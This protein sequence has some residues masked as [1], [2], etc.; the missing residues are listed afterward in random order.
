M[1]RDSPANTE[2]A[3]KVTGLLKSVF[4]GLPPTIAYISL[5][6]KYEEY[7]LNHRSAIYHAPK[8]LPILA[9]LI[10]IQAERDLDHAK[11]LNEI[12]NQHAQELKKIREE[13]DQIRRDMKCL[14]SHD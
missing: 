4:K 13:M 7:I 8:L 12:R 2:Y 5:F 14:T 6:K 3:H 10:V 1:P 9:A 11:Q